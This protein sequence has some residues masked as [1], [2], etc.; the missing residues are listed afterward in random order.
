M[1]GWAKAAGSQAAAKTAPASGGTSQRE[2]ADSVSSMPRA[3]AT[4]AARLQL[5]QTAATRRANRSSAAPKA[6]ATRL[7]AEIAKASST[8]AVN[9]QTVRMAW[10]AAPASA[11]M[12]VAAR[13]PSIRNTV[14]SPVRANRSPPTRSSWLAW[15]SGAGRG[16]PKRRAMAISARPA[17]S[18][19]LITVAQA[20]PATPRA[21]KGP[22]PKISSQS[23]RTLRALMATA[24]FSGAR[25]SWTPR[26]APKA[27][28]VTS[29]AGAASSRM[30]R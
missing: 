21:G 17:P 6:V 30:R 12:P 26:R 11:P 25:M 14:S 13:V 9:S 20:A 8:S 3:M 10:W 18:H 22:T 1:S 16:Q 7:W 5:Q 2:N 19:W 24:T 15:R 27:T 4:P 23:S 29:T 28:S